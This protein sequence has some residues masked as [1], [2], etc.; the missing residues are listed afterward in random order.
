MWHLI[1]GFPMNL[2]ATMTDPLWPIAV[3]VS[4]CLNGGS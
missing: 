4:Q 1:V 3:G 2:E